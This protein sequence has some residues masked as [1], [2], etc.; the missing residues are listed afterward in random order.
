LARFKSHRYNEYGETEEGLRLYYQINDWSGFVQSDRD[1]ATVRI[2]MTFPEDEVKS[3]GDMSAGGSHISS[4][5]AEH[6]RCFAVLGDLGAQYGYTHVGTLQETL[7]KHDVFD[8]YVC[9]ETIEHLREPDENLA[10]IRQHCKYLLLTTPIMETPELV[11]H[12]HLW[13][14]EREDVEDMLKTAGFTP[15]YFEQVSVFGIW[16]CR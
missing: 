16:K 3:V 11:S 9:S 5:I 4:T 12:G 6:Y 8:L 2:G 10:L 1:E 14:W 13:T 7:P 15:T